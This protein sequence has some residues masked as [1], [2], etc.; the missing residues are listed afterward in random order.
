MPAQNG[1][2]VDLP[3]HQV[4]GDGVG[5]LARHQRP[6]CSIAAGV[7]RQ[8]RIVVVDRP[9]TRRGQHLAGEHLVVDDAEEIVERPPA[10][11]RAKIARHGG[12]RDAKLGRPARQP[13]IGR[14]NPAHGVAMTQHDLSALQRQRALADDHAAK[15]LVV[16]CRLSVVHRPS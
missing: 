4:P 9:A 16:G 7:A 10:D 14:D 1:A 13:R 3:G 6:G 2:G 11:Q 12:V 8:R 5:L 15:L